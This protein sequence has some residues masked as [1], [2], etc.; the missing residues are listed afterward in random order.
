M[1]LHFTAPYTSAHNGHVEQMHRTLMGKARTMRLYADLPANLW[2]ELYLTASHLHAKT[3]TR[4]LKDIT[5]FEMWHGRKLDYS[6]MCEIGCK[7]L[8]S[9]RTDITQKSTSAQLNA[10]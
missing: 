8:Y 1:Q 10:C 3:P 7:A 4:S 9:F 2:D 6:Y 5:P